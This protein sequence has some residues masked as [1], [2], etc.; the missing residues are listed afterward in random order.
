M[1]SRTSQIPGVEE[2]KEEEKAIAQDKRKKRK[3]S[4]SLEPKSFSRTQTSA[5]IA[6]MDRSSRSSRGSRSGGSNNRA[7]N[8][9]CR[10]M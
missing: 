2:K 5:G 4:V 8:L 3:A 6:T 9:R 7:Y 10:E 1:H